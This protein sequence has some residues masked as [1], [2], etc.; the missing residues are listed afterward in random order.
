MNRL[1]IVDI[2][3]MK[4]IR[5]I[6]CLTAYTASI[7][8]AIENYV[9]IILIG[10]SLGT[11][12]YGMS[13]TQSVNMD[14]MESHGKTVV[15]SSNKPFTI[16]DMP[17]AS[18]RNYKKAF[19]NASKLIKNTGCQS[20]KIEVNNKDIKTV[21]YLTKKNIQVVSHIGVKPQSFSNFSKIKAVGKSKSEKTKLLNLA[22]KLEDAG[23]CM[24]LLECVYEETAKEITSMVNI[25]TIGIGSSVYCDGQILVV[26]DLLGLNTNLHK[27]KFIKK[28][29]NLSLEI[30]KSVKKYSQDIKKKKFPSKKYTYR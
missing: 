4:N 24:L 20:V 26:N 6:V 16:I 2:Q 30:R 27:P 17:Y 5:P 3:K 21:S 12:I 8:K 1:K 22:L 23:S 25:P 13:N 14:M 11:A 7:T 15:Q 28:Y 9:D 19:F 18:Y 10:D 29:S